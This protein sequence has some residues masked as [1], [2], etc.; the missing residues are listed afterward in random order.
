MA[1]AADGK[2]AIGKA[3]ATTPDVAVL[4]F[5]MPLIN[6]VEA[7]ASVPYR[8]QCRHCLSVNP[9]VRISAHAHR[10]TG[11]TVFFR[12]GLLLRVK[13]LS[14]EQAT[15]KGAVRISEP[16]DRLWKVLCLALTDPSKGNEQIALSD[17]RA[18]CCDGWS[19][20]EPPH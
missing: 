20:T 7:L 12:R 9:R 18:P 11:A 2:D 6:G 16:A 14:A 3:V 19:R 4:D 1:E 17:R 15:A 13:R 5:I 10:Q 8:R